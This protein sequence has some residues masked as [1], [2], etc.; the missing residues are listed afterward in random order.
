MMHLRDAGG[1]SREK[2][3]AVTFKFKGLK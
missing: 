2:E 1:A 3:F